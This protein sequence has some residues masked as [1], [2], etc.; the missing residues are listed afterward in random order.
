MTENM[1]I[2][3]KEHEKTSYRGQ[4][5][6]HKMVTTE[7][8]QTRTRLFGHGAGAAGCEIFPQMLP[9]CNFGSGVCM[10]ECHANVR[11]TITKLIW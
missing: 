3:Q 5:L 7:N 1:A 6:T 2:N 4:G 10:A 9:L 8:L 11:M